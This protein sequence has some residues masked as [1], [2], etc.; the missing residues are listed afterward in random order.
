MT[1]K[2][3]EQKNVVN[4]IWLKAA[5]VGGSWASVEIIVGSFLHNLRFPFAGA[6]LASF[7]V[8]LMVAF[9]RLWPVRGLIWRAGVVCALMKSISPSAIIMGPMIGILTEA[10]L[11]NIFISLFG[12]SLPAL[13][14]AGGIAVSAAF[15]QKI[16]NILILYGMNLVNVYL[17]LFDFASRQIGYTHSNPWILILVLAAIYFS[18][19]MISAIAGYMVGKRSKD[20]SD[21][22]ELPA[23][24]GNRNLFSESE[25]RSYSLTFLLANLL[26][27]PAGI[28]LLN[29]ANLWLSMPVIAGYLV[30]CLWYYPVIFRR[31]RIP[32]FWVQIIIVIVLSGLFWESAH[33]TEGVFD[34]QGVYAGIEMSMRAL[35]VI[36]GFT[37][38]STELRNPVVK[39]FLS[40]KGLRQ[41]YGS[42]SLAFQALPAMIEGAVKP[43]NVVRRPTRVVAAMLANAGK[44]EKLF[45]QENNRQ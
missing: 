23:L 40:R 3:F 28:L 17:N 32:I 4:S 20:M 18:L 30:F 39:A 44:W 12:R 14:I 13:M 6:V 11:L 24:S 10:I 25:N 2:N 43:G 37:A 22:S 31:L 45:E 26:A 27:I 42:V 8:M 16:F 33:G 41:V 29:R 35:L 15:A 34:M 9:Y 7:G 5:V 19:G 1:I 21:Q 38:I 36:S